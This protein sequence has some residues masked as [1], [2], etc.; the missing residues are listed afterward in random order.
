MPGCTDPDASNYDPDA[1]VDDGS[2]FYEET[3]NVDLSAGWNWISYLPQSGNTVGDALANIGDSGDFIK[4]QSS[5][6]NYYQGYGWFADGGLENMMPLDGFKIVMGEAASLT[7]TDPP[8]G[9]LTRTILSEPVNSPW[10][11]DHH[12]FEHSMTIVGVLMIDDEES[13][14]LGED[15]T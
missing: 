11:I 12:A 2:C 6:A 9:A 8:E 1:T 10:E 5:F 7:Y 15:N 13:M 4:N 3:V 14:D